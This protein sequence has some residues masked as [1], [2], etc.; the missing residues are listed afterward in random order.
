APASLPKYGAHFDL[1]MAIALLVISGQLPQEALK[2]TL[3]AGELA[4]DGSLRA[5][6]GAITHAAVAVSGAIQTVILPAQSAEQAALVDNVTV[7]AATSLK[8][9]FRH[10]INEQPLRTQTTAIVT[11]Q[12]AE[13]SVIDDIRGQDQAKRALTIAA[14]GRHNILLSGPPG[15][16]KTMLAKALVDILPPLSRSEVIEVTKLHSLAGENYASAITSRPFRSPHHSSSHIALVG[17]GTSPRP[18]QISLA[19]RGVLF[20]DELPEYNRQ[21]LESLRQPL[22]D[23][24]IS[25]ARA[26]ESVSFPADFML[27]ATRNPCPCGYASDPEHECSC[28]PHAIEQYQKKLSGPLLDRIDMTITISRVD[29]TTLL[30]VTTSHDQTRHAKEQIATALIRQR[31]RFNTDNQTNA[32]LSSKDIER[33]A[34]LE[35]AARTLMERAGHNLK[36]SARSYFKIIKVARTIA[37]I[38]DSDVIL[39]SHLSEALQYRARNNV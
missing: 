10:L 3:L 26:N 19:H 25:I 31:R 8:D 24:S 22:E 33:L 1:P 38:E 6:P 17:G 30:R 5:I 21:A 37:D 4:L 11:E 20:L 9:V 23:K 7:L 36:L 29:P 28:R 18:G 2:S 13:T 12:A 14:A 32:N 34:Y 39:G 27:V 16:G 15:A 35:P